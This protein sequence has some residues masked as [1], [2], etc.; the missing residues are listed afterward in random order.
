MFVMLKCKTPELDVNP[1][2]QDNNNKKDKLGYN[3]SNYFCIGKITINS[4]QSLSCVQLFA[5]P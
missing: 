3:M 1:R 4:V 5:T 2:S